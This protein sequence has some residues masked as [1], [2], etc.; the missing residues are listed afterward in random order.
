MFNKTI[1]ICWFQ[2]FEEAPP[3]IK[4]CLQTWKYYN[5]DWNIV[6]L[7]NQN[8]SDYVDLE[9]EIP[10]IR[11]FDGCKPA[12]LSDIVRLFVLNEYGGVWVDATCFCTKPLN[13]W[14]FER[15]DDAFLF[16]LPDVKIASWFI[17]SEVNS[18]V[19]NHWKNL[20][21]EY[22]NQKIRGMDKYDNLYRWVHQLF[23]D[24]YEKDEKLKEIYDRW[25]HYSAEWGDHLEFGKGPSL[26]VPYSK[27]LNAELHHTVKQ[28]I[29]RNITPLYKL[30]RH[31][32]IDFKN[33]NS[34]ICYLFESFTDKDLG[35]KE[36]FDLVLNN[37]INKCFD[38]GTV[39]L[40]FHGKKNGFYLPFVDDRMR[41]MSEKGPFDRWL[42]EKYTKGRIKVK[43]T[44]TVIDCGAFVGAFAIYAFKAEAEKVYAIE[45][46]SRNFHCLN[47][48]IE[49]YGADSI[50]EP[51]NIGLGDKCNRLRLN[52]SSMSCED[53]FL[54]CD[55][56]SINDYEEVDILT[57]KDFI[58]QKNIDV[59][60]LY[61]KIEA[62]GFEPE[63]LDGLGNL[64]PRV[65][66]IDVS[67]ERNGISPRKQLKKVLANNN[68]QTVN[69]SRCLFGV[70]LTKHP[71]IGKLT[72][73]FAQFF[74]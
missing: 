67:P 33:K 36:N 20:T 15:L 44:D 27:N 13:D 26:F 30:S 49:H 58:Q 17:A 31:Y 35:N 8:I 19:I 25:N 32:N 2:G 24:E 60:N 16:T 3:L 40:S 14:L 74:R 1:W 37:Q 55:A 18:Y 72:N 28:D 11:S 65:I 23:S 64:R 71:L 10:E 62:E 9:S 68:Y 63:I 22:W 39:F 43:Q 29:D 69:T 51:V 12:A 50:V 41:I 66:V 34:S 59:N 56:G 4:A 5:S 7:N 53:S 70:K 21:V 47:K 48:N 73:K 54:E 38:D 52:L 6:E 57:L 46:S 61:L 45:P 42:Q